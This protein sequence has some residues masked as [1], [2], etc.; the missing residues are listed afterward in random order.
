MCIIHVCICQRFWRFFRAFPLLLSNREM[1]GSEIYKQDSNESG[2]QTEES[3]STD[4][5][6]LK[7]KIKGEHQHRRRRAT[8]THTKKKFFPPRPISFVFPYIFNVLDCVHVYREI[9]M[10]AVLLSFVRCFFLVYRRN[11]VTSD[12]NK[13]DIRKREREINN[14]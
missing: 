13:N 14:N 6:A 1:N 5:V 11:V 10:C 8:H 3:V 4:S 12:P 2:M 7:K 9:E